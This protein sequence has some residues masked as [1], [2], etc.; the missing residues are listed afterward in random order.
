M[1]GEKAQSFGARVVKRAWKGTL[2][3]FETTAR[4]IVLALALAAVALLAQLYRGGFE[5]VKADLLQTLWQTALPVGAVGLCIFL[6]NIWLAPFALIYE[7]TANVTNSGARSTT[8]SS[9]IKQINWAPW[10]HRAR[11]TVIEFAQILAK[12]DPASQTLNGEAISFASLL[13]E[14]CKTR[15]LPYIPEYSENYMGDTYEVEVSEWTAVPR[16]ALLTW[17]EQKKFSVDHVR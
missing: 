3:T 17:A 15:K 12:S 7:A 1:A 10:K 5:A 13:K 8:P 16:D 2:E 4:A 9:P 14:E 11:Y 6:W